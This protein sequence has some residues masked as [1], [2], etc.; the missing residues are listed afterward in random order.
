MIKNVFFDLDDTL[1]DFHRSEKIALAK[2][3]TELGISPEEKTLERYSVINDE[4]WKLLELGKL[5]RSEVKVRRYRILF[6]EIG[7]G[8]SPEEAAKIYEQKLS[9]EQYFISGAEELL[10]AMQGKYRMFLVSNGTSVVQH[11]RLESSGICKYFENIFISEEVGY[12][13]PSA[14]FFDACFAAI[15]DFRREESVIIGDSL[16]SDIK[17]GQNAGI[18]TIWFRAKNQPARDGI[19][20]DYTVTSLSEIPDLLLKI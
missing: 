9:H 7:C 13:K 19:V 18:T 20:P 10:C 4:Q 3:L 6:E 14:M 17:G 15:P 5:K 2:T 16:T 11:G 12:D 1:F 8:A